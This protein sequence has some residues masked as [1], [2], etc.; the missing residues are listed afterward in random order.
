MTKRRVVLLIGILLLLLATN[1]VYSEQFDIINNY[2]T[3][4]SM[5]SACGWEERY[6]GS[7]PGNLDSDG[8]ITAW[9]DRTFWGCETHTAAV[10]LCQHF[11]GTSFETI[12]CPA[13][14]DPDNRLRY[15]SF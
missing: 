6:C 14:F 4:S 3:D 7:E 1:S 11:N 9:R 8:T 2:Y 13:T 10:V 15:P 12:E 5:T